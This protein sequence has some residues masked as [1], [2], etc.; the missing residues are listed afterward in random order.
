MT[1]VNVAT[2]STVMNKKKTLFV[3]NLKANDTKCRVRILNPVYGWPSQN[4]TDSRSGTLHTVK[5]RENTY[6]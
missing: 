4:V 5:L 6:R 3:G 1:D 2:I